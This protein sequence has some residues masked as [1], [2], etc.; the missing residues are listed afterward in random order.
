MSR[1]PT[2]DMCSV[3]GIG[4]ADMV[5]TSTCLR[6]CL[7]RSL[8]RHAEALLLVDDQQPEIGELHVLRK[9]PVRADQD[10]DLARLPLSAGFLSA[11]SDCGSG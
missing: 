10:V 11:A 4:V 7:M 8:C 6:I 3:R 5:S 9:N 2:I 1:S